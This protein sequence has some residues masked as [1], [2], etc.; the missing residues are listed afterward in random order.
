[1]T[2][3]ARVWLA[4]SFRKGP[5]RSHWY[6][7]VVARLAPRGHLPALHGGQGVR[8]MAPPALPPVA[9]ASAWAASARR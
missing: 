4:R 2:S 6:C 8:T 1:M 9:W 7:A 5:G 3:H